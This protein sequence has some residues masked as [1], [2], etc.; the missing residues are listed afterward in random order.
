MKFVPTRYK[1]S[2]KDSCHFCGF[3]VS[4]QSRIVRNFP[5]FIGIVVQAEKH[6]SLVQSREPQKGCFF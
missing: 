1:Q 4:E 6:F 3:V 2:V 5:D